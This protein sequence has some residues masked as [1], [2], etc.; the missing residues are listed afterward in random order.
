MGLLPKLILL[1]RGEHALGQPLL[2]A[3]GWGRAPRPVLFGLLGTPSFA[4]CCHGLPGEMGML[5]GLALGWDRMG[6]RIPHCGKTS[7]LQVFLGVSDFIL[8]T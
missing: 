3:P 2:C 7:K 8:M 4:K 5:L 1:G 6:T